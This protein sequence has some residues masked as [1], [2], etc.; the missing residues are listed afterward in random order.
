MLLEDAISFLPSEFNTSEIPLGLLVDRV[1]P[2]I[3][4]QYTMEC[5]MPSC[6]YCLTHHRWSKI[7]H[8]VSKATQ[9]FWDMIDEL[10]IKDGLLTKGNRVVIPTNLRDYFLMTYMIHPKEQ[11]NHKQ[12][13]AAPSIGLP[14]I[15]ILQTI[16]NAARPAW[17]L[18]RPNPLSPL[19]GI[20]SKL[21]CR[22]K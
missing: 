18:T 5:P 14:P 7:G 1:R 19:S 17:W 20:K 12:K 3:I 9:R 13:L 10:S 8:L 4:C 22:R 15:L 2:A 6:V 11:I 16:W 21:P